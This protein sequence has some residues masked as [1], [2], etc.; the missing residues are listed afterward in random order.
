MQFTY[1]AVLALLATYAQGD[2]CNPL[3]SPADCPP[4]CDGTN[5]EARVTAG[6]DCGDYPE[7]GGGC[8]ADDHSMTVSLLS[9]NVQIVLEWDSLSVRVNMT[10]AC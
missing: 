1:F 4:T 10:D 3:G 9:S 7:G 2:P 5:C 8:S 6:D